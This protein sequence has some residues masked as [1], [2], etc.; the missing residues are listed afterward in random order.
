M[1]Q[2]E[3]F[4]IRIDPKLW[5]MAKV[6]AATHDLKLGQFIEKVLSEKLKQSS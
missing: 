3:T 6:Y 5:K 1:T 2:K 4:S